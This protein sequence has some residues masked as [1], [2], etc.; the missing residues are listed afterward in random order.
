MKYFLPIVR[1]KTDLE[2]A[3]DIGIWAVNGIG[4]TISDIN[5]S[6]FGDAHN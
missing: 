1:K 3:R 5:I 2:L 6:P 4:N